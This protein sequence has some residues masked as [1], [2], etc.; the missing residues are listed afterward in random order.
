MQEEE[1][2]PTLTQQRAP[3]RAAARG[4]QALGGFVHP[5]TI[6]HER[7]RVKRADLIYAVGVA[8]AGSR[9]FS[10]GA[11]AARAYL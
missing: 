9:G 2:V 6:P 3:V 1:L 7:G 11:G 10:L 5:P 4:Q 8:W